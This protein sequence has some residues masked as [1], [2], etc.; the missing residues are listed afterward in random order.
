MSRTL[1]TFDFSFLDKHVDIYN[2][3][4]HDL[5]NSFIFTD[6]IVW[7]FPVWQAHHEGCVPIGICEESTDG[8]GAYIAMVFEDEDGNR[9]Y[10]H[11]PA[12]W[13]DEAKVA[14]LGWEACQEARYNW[15]HNFK[16][17]RRKS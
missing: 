10:T 9:Y 3:G 15:W 5:D 6:F 12:S 2:L 11:V 16:I 4:Q 8:N 1:P 13:K 7:Q 14:H 17:N